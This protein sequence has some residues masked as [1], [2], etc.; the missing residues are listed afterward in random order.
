MSID[1]VVNVATVREKWR[2]KWGFIEICIKGFSDCE[3]IASRTVDLEFA[4]CT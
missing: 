4:R 2:L 1:K 3:R